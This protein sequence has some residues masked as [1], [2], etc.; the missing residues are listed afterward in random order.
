MGSQDLSYDGSNFDKGLDI[1]FEPQEP[2]SLA[3]MSKREIVSDGLSGTVRGVGKSLTNGSKW[4]DAVRNEL[5]GPFKETW[6]TF[7]E[8]SNSLADLQRK[9]TKEVKPLLGQMAK[10]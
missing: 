6:K 7:D 9:A 2:K 10:T 3:E 5:P 1:S 4:I 8:T